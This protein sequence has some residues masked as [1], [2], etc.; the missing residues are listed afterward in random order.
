MADRQAEGPGDAEIWGALKIVLGGVTKPIRPLPANAS[1]AWTELLSARLREAIGGVKIS[2]DDWGSILGR[3][4]GLTRLQTELLV[5]YDRDGRLGGVEWI[6]DNATPLEIWT[7]FK[8]VATAAYPPLADAVRFPQL[9]AGL[10]PQL[11]ASSGSSDS[12][13]GDAAETS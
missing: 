11:L 8:Q 7:A 3:F 5:A 6:G 13:S 4:A 1:E 10:L 12:P 2:G 9:L